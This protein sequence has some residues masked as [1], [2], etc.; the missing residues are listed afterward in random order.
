MV[1]GLEDLLC[2]ERLRVETLQPGEAYNVSK[3][4]MGTG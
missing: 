3:Y 2:E 4:T 1:K